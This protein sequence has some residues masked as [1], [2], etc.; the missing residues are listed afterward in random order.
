[1]PDSLPLE[2]LGTFSAKEILA[3]HSPNMAPN[4]ETIQPS[5]VQL[6]A[7][8]INIPT[9]G[10]YGTLGNLVL[11]IG[12]TAYQ[13]LSLGNIDHPPPAAPPAAPT[14]PQN[15]TE[16]QIY[17]ARCTFYNIVRGF[18]LYHTLDAV[19]KQQLLTSIDEK[20]V[21]VEKNCNTGYAR[22]TIITL[23]NH[24]VNTYVQITSD[25]LINN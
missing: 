3:M 9:T 17:E 7:N 2:V 24:L 11:T 5:L 13:A 10:G 18:K 25:Y 20:Y 14:F 6:N 4:F 19:L 8:A 21:K 12:C 15:S 22:I 1:M 23:I 16:A